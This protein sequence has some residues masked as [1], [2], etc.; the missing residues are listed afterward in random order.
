MYQI[1]TNNNIQ[2]YKDYSL[3]GQIRPA[4]SVKLFTAITFNTEENYQEVRQILEEKL[5][6]VD[7]ESIK[8]D[9]TFTDYY[10]PEMG[11]D[12]KKQFISFEQLIQP[13]K[14]TEIK[15]WTNEIED[16]YAI[17]HKRQLNID[18]G[19]LTSAKIVLATTK[20][21]SHRIYLSKGIYG[22]IH[23]RYFQRKF[24]FFD[25]TYA[26]YKQPLATEFFSQM[27]KSYKSSYKQKYYI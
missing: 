6:K 2:L 12:L 24:H 8:F 5:G 3:M 14:L 15:V 9:F 16:Q 10:A 1:V 17:E 21:F 13:D 27:R 11:I 4:D 18:P 26:D 22:D 7:I 20:N 23:M 25:W 19:Y